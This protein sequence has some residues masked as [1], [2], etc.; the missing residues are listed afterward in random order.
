[1]KHGRVIAPCTIMLPRIKQQIS[2]EVSLLHFALDKF[3]SLVH[4]AAEN[5]LSLMHYPAESQIVFHIMQLS[6]I[7]Q[8]RVKKKKFAML[9]VFSNTIRK[10]LR[11]WRLYYPRHLRYIYL[12]KLA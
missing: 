1:M 9:S 2:G 6:Q 11:I 7:W 12:R 3:D 8:C 10:K 5:Q 4:D